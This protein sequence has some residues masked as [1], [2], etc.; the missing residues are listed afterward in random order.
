MAEAG[1]DKK[2]K[3]GESEGQMVRDWFRRVADS[4]VL[5]CV[6]MQPVQPE[7]HL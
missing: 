4:H 3:D 6:E 2:R 5:T 1:G 7:L